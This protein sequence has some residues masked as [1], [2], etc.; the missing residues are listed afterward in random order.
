MC[1][2]VS[3]RELGPR[4]LKH[5]VCWL[6]VGVLRSSIMK[7]VAGGFSTCLRLLLRRWFLEY[8]IHDEGV[9]LDLGLPTHRHAAFYLQLGNILA[10]GDAYRAAWSAKGA[11][12][13]VPC[14]SRK[15]VV[16][17][18][19]LASPCLARFSCPDPQQF[20]LAT[21]AEIW[22]KADA[23]TSSRG[24][25]TKAAFER[26]QMVHGLTDSPS[27]LLWDVELRGRVKPAGAIALD[28]MHIAVGNGIVQN[29]VGWLFSA[30]KERGITWKMVLDFCTRIDWRF[31]K[32][33]GSRAKLLQCLG[34]ARE[35]AW[36]S[37]GVFKGGASE[38]LMVYPIL[39]HV[40]D[41]VV[42]PRRI[43]LDHLSSFET[44][45]S[46]LDLV[47]RGKAGVPVHEQLAAD[48]K[49]HGLRCSVAYP[50][51]SM[52]PKNHY[53]HHLPKQLKRDTLIIDAFVGE[54]KNGIIKR[55]SADIL[56]TS[57]FEK[58][59]IVRVLGQQIDELSSPT[60]FQDRLER[61]VRFDA[62]AALHGARSASCAKCAV[63]GG[64]HLWADDALVIDDSVHIIT[65]GC[66]IDGKIWLATCRGHFVGHVT[67][68]ASR[69][70]LEGES[71][72]VDLGGEV[73]QMVEAWY[74]DPDGSL[75]A[76][77]RQRS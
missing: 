35:E 34:T 22:S 61:P 4:F 54:R 51:G 28:A 70:T 38:M 29:E 71:R 16:A 1:I 40:C 17:V 3:I 44:I 67:S 53:L 36:K 31:C 77:Y 45:G 41:K 48:I 23:L 21:N 8:R 60:V 20:D 49:L 37:S 2:Y 19:G 43:L 75:V 24:T 14:L 63:I 18:S 9:R 64:T 39:M 59:A 32:A 33:L 62:L 69:W 58:S 56:N 10:D 12:G 72:L 26:L 47:R 25:S 73:P 27:G 76:L 6:P 5:E 46:V 30:L 50:A 13:N 52:K 65:A 11:S 15:N 7:K 74:H 55:L 68:T 57:T 42:R 66:E